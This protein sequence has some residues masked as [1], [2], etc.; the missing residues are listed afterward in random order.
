[1]DEDERPELL[2]SLRLQEHLEGLDAPAVALLIMLIGMAA[3]QGVTVIAVSAANV[4]AYASLHLDRGGFQAAFAA[5]RLKRLVKPVRPG[6]YEIASGYWKVAVADPSD[7]EF[8]PFP[9]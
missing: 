9:G 6:L 7:E 2:I 3:E 5:L 8:R 4:A 1:M